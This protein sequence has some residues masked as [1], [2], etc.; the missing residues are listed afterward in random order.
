MASNQSSLSNVKCLLAYNGR[1]YFGFSTTNKQKS[2]ERELQTALEKI[3]QHPVKIQAAS[4]TDRGVHAEGQVINFTTTAPLNLSK[5]HLSLRSLLPKDISP[6]EL[7]IEEPNFHPTL[8]AKGKEYHYWVCNVPTQLPFH[9]PFSWHVYSPLDLPKM[10]FAARSLV[11]TKDF[12]ALSNL[13]YTNPI[14]TIRRI[15]LFPEGNRLR[16]EVE[17]DNF[18]YKMVRNIIGTLIDIGTEKITLE[19]FSTLLET[20]DRRFAGV[21]APAHGLFLKRVFY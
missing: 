17:G 13:S 5:L 8:D 6:L 14:R 10:E 16:F 15:E 1:N 12:S 4:R 11:G 2:V 18:L 7:S 3:F 19:S 9:S 21:T 20:K